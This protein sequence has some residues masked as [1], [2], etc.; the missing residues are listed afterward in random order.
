MPDKGVADRE[1]R[2]VTLVQRAYRAQ[3]A[4][5]RHS[6][7]LVK[8]SHLHLSNVS[9][10]LGGLPS[11]QV[12]CIMEDGESR[13][14]REIGTPIKRNDPNPTFEDPISIQLPGCARAP[15]LS[16]SVFTDQG[17]MI[18][19]RRYRVY[20]KEQ[21]LQGFE[22]DTTPPLPSIWIDAEIVVYRGLETIVFA[23][24][25]KA[26]VKRRSMLRKAGPSVADL[27]LRDVEKGMIAVYGPAAASSGSRSAGL[28]TRRFCIAVAS[29]CSA[30]PVRSM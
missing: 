17:E 30:H 13:K 27:A 12:C 19:S 22:L 3:T 1:V 25:L 29:R 5:R 15:T 11:V 10:P 4:Y 16:I 21:V 7:I 2:A 8:L 24:D 28:R 14:S 9:V 18:A 23:S 6:P 20:G 26:Q